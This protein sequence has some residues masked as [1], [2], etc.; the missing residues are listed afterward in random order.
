MGKLSMP[1]IWSICIAGLL[2]GSPDR[3]G[4][5]HIRPI[6]KLREVLRPLVGAL[7]VVQT[8][9]GTAEGIFAA[10]GVAA[11]LMPRRKVFI[12]T[13]EALAQMQERG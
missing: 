1:W 6:R 5:Y 13:R 10:E 4:C 8:P 3:Y 11:R 2:S 9:L 7:P 12:F